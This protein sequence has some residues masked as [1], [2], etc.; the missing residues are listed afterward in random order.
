MV[1]ASLAV[2]VKDIFLNSLLVTALNKTFNALLLK[3]AT[4]IL[5]STQFYQ[6]FLWLGPAYLNSLPHFLI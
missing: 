5:A 4:L 1:Q 2:S 6:R 3:F